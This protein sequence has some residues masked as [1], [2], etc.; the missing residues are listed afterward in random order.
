MAHVSGCQVHS[1]TQNRLLSS[2]STRPYDASLIQSNGRSNLD[3]LS[4][5]LELV[6][7]FL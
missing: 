2:I 4:N 7:Q 5:G 6:A 3:F 1:F